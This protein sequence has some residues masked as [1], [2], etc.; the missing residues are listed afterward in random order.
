MTASARTCVRSDS[1]ALRIVV[2]A[3]ARFA[4]LGDR[5]VAS[6]PA[7]A[8]RTPPNSALVTDSVKSRLSPPAVTGRFPLVDVDLELIILADGLII[9][10]LSSDAFDPVHARN[11]RRKSET[12]Y[13]HRCKLK[14]SHKSPGSDAI[15]FGAEFEK[16]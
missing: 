8:L 9:V 7:D 14:L 11:T 4:C 1:C 5:P 13:R 6:I 12:A 10:T 3:I 2:A 16:W 15:K